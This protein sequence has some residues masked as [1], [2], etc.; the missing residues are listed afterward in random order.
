MSC[1]L[2]CA[3]SGSNKVLCFYSQKPK[4]ECYAAMRTCEN[5]IRRKARVDS[6]G[7]KSQR[8]NGRGPKVFPFHGLCPL[9]AEPSRA[10][11]QDPTLVILSLLKTE[12]S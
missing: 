4:R 6:K 11:I 1:L 9:G 3:A 5:D 8:L 12:A 2:H 7:L 10:N